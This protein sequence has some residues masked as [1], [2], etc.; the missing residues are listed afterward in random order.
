MPKTAQYPSQYGQG[1]YHAA[2]DNLGLLPGVAPVPP[3]DTG[4]K[5]WMIPAALLAA[6]GLG[7]YALLRGAG[8]RLGNLFK[9]KPPKAPA[10]SWSWDKEMLGRSGAQSFLNPETTVG[11]TIPGIKMSSAKL[12]TQLANLSKKHKSSELIRTKLR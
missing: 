11:G 4:D 1:G 8:R 5:S 10:E 7:G 9:Y 2:M 12:I 3:P 6:T